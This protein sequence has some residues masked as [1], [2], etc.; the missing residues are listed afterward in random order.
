MIVGGAP[1]GIK[2]R[3]ENAESQ[4]DEEHGVQESA[5]DS[6]LGGRRQTVSGLLLAAEERHSQVRPASA[7]AA[8]R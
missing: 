6:L 5:T 8:V 1:L 2:R 7:V 3:V 4:S